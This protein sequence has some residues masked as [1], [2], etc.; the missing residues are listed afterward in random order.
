M[1][2]DCQGRNAI[3]WILPKPVRVSDEFQNVLSF[4]WKSWVI[5]DRADSQGPTRP[6]YFGPD[7]QKFFSSSVEARTGAAM[8]HATNRAPQVMPRV[9]RKV[10]R[11][12]MGRPQC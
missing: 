1:L 4:S 11:L 12:R 2:S 8:A 7:S 10:L 6:S 3:S 5:A 9:L